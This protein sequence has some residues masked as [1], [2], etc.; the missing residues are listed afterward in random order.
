MGARE[1]EA[2]GLG[3][4]NVTAT[5][6]RAAAV[7]CADRIA[8]EHPGPMDDLMPRLAGKQLAHD[9]AARDDVLELLDAIGYP[10]REQT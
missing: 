2:V 1:V 5:Q 3:P 9:P 8:A 10:S 4:V 7:H 6:M